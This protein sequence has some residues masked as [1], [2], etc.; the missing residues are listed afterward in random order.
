MMQLE[1]EFLPMFMGFSIGAVIFVLQRLL[2]A[3]VPAPEAATAADAPAKDDVEEEPAEDSAEEEPVGEPGPEPTPRSD[4]P[5]PRRGRRTAAAAVVAAAALLL[6][7]LVLAPEGPPAEE[8]LANSAAPEAAP[9]E[10]APVEAAPVVNPEPAPASASTATD[11]AVEEEEQWANQSIA[12]QLAD[13]PVVRLNLTRQQVAV[14][15]SSLG[16]A[17]YYKSAYWGTVTVGS[18][19]VPFKVVFDTGSGHLIVPSTYCHSETCR[20]HKRYRRSTS[21]SAVDIDYDGAEV[22]PGEPRD[23]IT[24][25]FGTGEV[26]GIFIKD[27]ICPVG[28]DKK[29]EQVKAL[30]PQPSAGCIPLRMIAATDMSEEPFRTFE[31]DGVLG[32]GLPGL[33]QAPEFNF[34][35]VM[36]QTLASY[37]SRT[38]HIFSVFLAETENEMSEITLG[39]YVGDRMASKL[40]WNPVL[41][42]ELGHWMLRV[43]SVT[44]DGKK[45]GFCEEGDCRAVVDTGTSLLAV[46]TA[47][48][49]EIYELLRHEA[50]TFQE[51]KGPGP[52]L[53]I[54]LENFVV[55]LEPRDYARMENQLPELGETKLPMTPADDLVRFPELPP[56][57]NATGTD[58]Q[59]EDEA[60]ACKPMLMSMELPA[61]IGP[62]LFVLGEPVLRKYY[63]VYDSDENAPRIGFGRAWHANSPPPVLEEGD[64]M[65]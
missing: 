44:I 21:S 19:P 18:P 62:K 26:T 45:L 56:D 47:V 12:R 7:L 36:G 54:E 23:Q 14:M 11:V 5:R 3:D 32:M 28:H 24:V 53:S 34:L 29:P 52:K 49:P 63:T 15:Q 30:G 39:G 10:A 46:P 4:A 25:S 20:E 13:G 55:Q 33:S 60:P 50:D 6:L 38:P 1:L 57:F 31:F 8:M 27:L 17:I 22:K 51:C 42:P 64:D 48:F 16:D 65:P 43:R 58:E 59:P 40:S 35:H 41:D 9:V 61:P 37:G 2:A